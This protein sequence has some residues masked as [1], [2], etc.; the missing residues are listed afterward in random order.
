VKLYENDSAR[1]IPPPEIEEVAKP[2]V[3]KSQHPVIR[4]YSVDE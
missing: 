1:P 4:R 2:V 3:I